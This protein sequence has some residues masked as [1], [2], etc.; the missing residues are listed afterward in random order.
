MMVRTRNIALPGETGG[1]D[2]D[3]DIDELAEFLTP[4]RAVI[5]ETIDERD[6]GAW[7]EAH[8]RPAYRTAAQQRHTPL[9]NF[10]YHLLVLKEWGLIGQD[11]SAKGQEATFGLT[12]RGERLVEQ[13][14]PDMAQ[15]SLSREERSPVD[16]LRYPLRS[17]LKFIELV[18]SHRDLNQ[19]VA[20]IENQ[21][22]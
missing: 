6:K 9:Y 20:A 7:E 16:W 15:D 2:S 11:G 22:D 14:A 17:D 4:G 8:L 19:R 13:H 1:R 5:L 12:Y 21:L 3:P 10:E 18:A